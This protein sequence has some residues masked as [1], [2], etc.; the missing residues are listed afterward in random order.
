M[1]QLDAITLFPDMFDAL[2]ESGITRRAR[3][4]RRYQ[5]ICWNPRDFAHDNYRTIDDRPYGGGPGMVMMA[6]PLEAALGYAAD[7]S[8]G[9]GVV[10]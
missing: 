1:L 5:L 3:E 10:R 9:D 4:E 8:Q 6:A 2:T 7:P